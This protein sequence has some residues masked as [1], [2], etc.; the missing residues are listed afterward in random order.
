VCQQSRRVS[1]HCCRCAQVI[2]LGVHVIS[3]AFG[4]PMLLM[5][6]MPTLLARRAFAPPATRA[7]LE[8]GFRDSPDPAALALVFIRARSCRH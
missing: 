8:P 7:R 2:S 3:E 4:D 6:V 1:R 5:E